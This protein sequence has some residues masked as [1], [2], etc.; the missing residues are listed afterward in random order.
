[1]RAPDIALLQRDHLRLFGAYYAYT[2]GRVNLE[3][4]Y[5]KTVTQEYFFR[6][7][8]KHLGSY[9]LAVGLEL[10]S[11]KLGYTSDIFKY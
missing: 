9:I 8:P 7:I 2:S 6:R 10:E 1:M 4:D 11:I 3:T 5:N